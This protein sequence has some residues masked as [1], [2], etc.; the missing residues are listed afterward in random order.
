MSA[1]NSSI[2]IDDTDSRVNYET[3]GQWLQLQLNN[4][5]RHQ[6]S[7]AGATASL[8]FTGIGVH[9]IGM[10]EPSEDVGQPTTR[11]LIDGDVA[12]TYTAPFVPTPDSHL[13][14]TFFSFTNLSLGKHTITV[15]NMDGTTPNTVWLDYF[16]V[17]I[18]QGPSTAGTRPDPKSST[19]T[20]LPTSSSSAASVSVTAASTDTPQTSPTITSDVSTTGPPHTGH[21]ISGAVVGASVASGSILALL[22]LAFFCV[23]RRRHL[24]ASQEA[25]APFTSSC[26]PFVAPSPSTRSPSL[27]YSTYSSA[28]YSTR[29][30]VLA[31][32]FGHQSSIAAPCEVAPDERAVKN[33]FESES[34]QAI[35]PTP[36]SHPSF[37]ALEKS[38]CLQS[39]PDIRAPPLSSPPGAGTP[40]ARALRTSSSTP[41][42]TTP[43][44]PVLPRGMWHAPP[45]SNGSPTISLFRSFFSN[46]SRA[47]LASSD[48]RIAP[49]A[50]DSGLRLYDDT[51]LPPPYTRD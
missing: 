15:E 34:Q 8:S 37:P 31:S 6:T 13:N 5:T 4:V 44:V 28:M 36:V 39:P 2:F 27:R 12:G 17:D 29:A 19:T 22:A 32:H 10:L 49:R 23:R 9:V 42:T 24:H 1:S 41:V 43:A 48:P 45:G 35:S 25:V 3:D 46:G 20:D 21:L 30:V 51:V 40:L 26:N 11:Y 7:L 18:P 33:P 14:V 50:A 47:N 16:L 38:V